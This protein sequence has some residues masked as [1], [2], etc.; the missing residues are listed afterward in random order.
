M[1]ESSGTTHIEPG[2]NVSAHDMV[3]VIGE[4]GCF[5]ITVESSGTTHIE[6][7]IDTS[8]HDTVI[9]VELGGQPHGR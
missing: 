8:A 1:V 9:T 7:G 2:L 3:K 5:S 4:L 6:H